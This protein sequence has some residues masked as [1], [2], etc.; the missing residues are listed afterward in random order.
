MTKAIRMPPCSTCGVTRR[1]KLPWRR[2]TWASNGA[3]SVIESM[4][5]AI[6]RDDEKRAELTRGKR[7][8]LVAL[9]VALNRLCEP[10]IHSSERIGGEGEEREKSPLSFF[11][12]AASSRSLPLS[13]RLQLAVLSCLSVVCERRNSGKAMAD[14]PTSPH[15]VLEALQLSLAS[16]PNALD[17]ARLVLGQWARAPRFYAYLVDVFTSREGVQLEV[18][19]QAALQFKN[20]VEKYWRKGALQ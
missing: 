17:H 10:G 1:I 3:G 19:L 20:G 9:E 4:A 6:G 12:R 14:A 8:V 15:A 16:D 13:P 11:S 2:C 5:A 7:R 18:R